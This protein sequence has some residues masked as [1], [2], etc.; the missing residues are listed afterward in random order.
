MAGKFK[1]ILIFVAAYV[2]ITI[3]MVMLF[4]IT[5]NIKFLFVLPLGLGIT[6]L[7]L[8]IGILLDKEDYSSW[9]EAK[10]KIL[11]IEDSYYDYK[12]GER[13]TALPRLIIE[14][15]DEEGKKH[16]GESQRFKKIDKYKANDEVVFKYKLKESSILENIIGKEVAARIHI[17]D[18]QLQECNSK[19]TS[20]TIGIFGIFWII[21]AIITLNQ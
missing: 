14:F 5:Q 12:L 21:I 6:F 18:E 1:K 7:A 8:S 19:R 17:F 2:I 11:Y 4:V 13:R 9:K 20:I 3:A 10:G 15:V 16:K